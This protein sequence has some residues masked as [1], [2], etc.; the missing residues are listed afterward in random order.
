MTLE[1]VYSVLESKTYYEKGTMRKFS[2]VENAIHIDRRAF[3]PFSIYKEDEKVKHEEIPAEELQKVKNN[4]A[5]AEF[6]KL[7]IYPTTH[8]LQQYRDVQRVMRR[9]APHLHRQAIQVRGHHQQA[10]AQ[11]AGEQHDP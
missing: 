9:S 10:A 7:A 2:F 4:F 6:R 1:D 3:I 5:A 8:A 11:Q